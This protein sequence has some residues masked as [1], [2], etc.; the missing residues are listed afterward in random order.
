LPGQARLV[1]YA[2]HTLE[3]DSSV[4]WH[5]VINAAGRIS[6]GD[7][8]GGATTQRL[9]L[10]AEGIAVTEGGRISLRKFGWP[11]GKRWVT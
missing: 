6:L 4:P 9:R 1:G 5:R 3:G 7:A 8:R 11:A 2:L 10:A